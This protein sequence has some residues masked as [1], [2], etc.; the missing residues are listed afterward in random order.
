MLALTIIVRE[1]TSCLEDD[2]M[3]DQI[4]TNGHA[5]EGDEDRVP[6]AV[7]KSGT[8]KTP[9]PTPELLRR[10]AGDVQ[11]AHVAMERS[12]AESV[13]ADRVTMESSGVQ[14]MEVKSAQLDKSGVVMMHAERA[15]LHDSAAVVVSGEEV[16]LVNSRVVVIGTGKVESEGTIRAGMIGTGEIKSQGAVSGI[17]VS[18]GTIEADGGVRATFT[19]PAAAAFGAAFA[20]T[21]LLFGRLLRRIF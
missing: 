2:A 9:E 20:V 1:R 3:S 12:G 7:G 13:K 17:V 21:L 11:A 5:D 6:V 10:D 19:P 18:A 15:V 8:S 16:R 4:P 14:S